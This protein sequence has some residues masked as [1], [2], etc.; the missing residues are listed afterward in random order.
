MSEFKKN[1]N[2][3]L[4]KNNTREKRN[5]NILRI[6]S[7]ICAFFCVILIYLT[8]KIFDNKNA[9][10]QKNN[11]ISIRDSVYNELKEDVLITLKDI[12]DSKKVIIDS[13]TRNKVQRMETNIQKL[14]EIIFQGDSTVVRYYKRTN[15]DPIISSI[16]KE[17][18]FYL[19]VRPLVSDNGMHKVN[20]IYYGD[21]VKVEEVELLSYQLLKSDNEFKNIL[22][23]KLPKDYKWKI[24]AIELGYNAKYDTL[25]SLTE[26]DIFIKFHKNE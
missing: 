20:V 19:N 5:L 23:F 18:G 4:S 22:N 15:D 21:S 14:P 24:N 8:F 7:V 11:E 26:K 1:D 3:S 13:A 25:P 2:V 10:K 12:L 16:I 9:I 17:M 6:I